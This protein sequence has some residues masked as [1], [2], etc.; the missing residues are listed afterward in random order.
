MALLSYKCTASLCEENIQNV[1]DKSASQSNTWKKSKM[2]GWK[3]TRWIMKQSLKNLRY[4][5]CVY[6]K[7]I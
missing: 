5:F 4:S 3:T 6:F 7:Y 1:V 2:V